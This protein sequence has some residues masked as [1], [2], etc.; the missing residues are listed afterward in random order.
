M[1]IN[2]LDKIWNIIFLIFKTNKKKKK[3]IIGSLTG[4]VAF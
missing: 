4:V 2:K 3:F 1:P